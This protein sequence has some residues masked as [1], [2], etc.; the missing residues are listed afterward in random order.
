M[1]CLPIVDRRHRLLWTSG[2]SETLKKMSAL[3][4][5]AGKRQDLDLFIGVFGRRKD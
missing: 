3:S 2:G 5:M 4:R 1:E